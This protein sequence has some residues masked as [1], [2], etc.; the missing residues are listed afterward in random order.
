[1]TLVH[2]PESQYYGYQ[3]G[4]GANNVNDHH[5]SGGWFFF[6]GFFTDSSTG[7]SMDVGGYTEGEG[8]TMGDFAF[9]HDCCPDY[10]IE[11]TW[12]AYDCTGNFVCETQTISF[13][14][15]EEEAPG[16]NFPALSDAEEFK[17]D[18]GI[19][20]VAPNPATDY[21][22]VEFKSNINSTLILE[23]YDLSGR[24]VGTLYNGNVEKDELYRVDYT[25]SQLESGVYNIRLYSL[26][27]Q[28]NEKLVISK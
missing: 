13:E 20:K 23:V 22:Y 2:A 27:H 28:V 7:F 14:E 17:G 6:D 16:I 26:S 5:G 19:V 4:T 15:L 21:A 24:V 8:G 18:F 1:L 12:C 25:T 11:R 9:D 10:T 3:V